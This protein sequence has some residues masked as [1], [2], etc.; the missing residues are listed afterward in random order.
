MIFLYI[1]WAAL[2]SPFVT[3][4]SVKL[5]RVAYLRANQWFEEN[6]TATKTSHV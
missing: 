6:K 2:L 5:G 3:F 1:L 4:F